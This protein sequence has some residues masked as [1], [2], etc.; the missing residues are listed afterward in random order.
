MD[1]TPCK[2]GFGGKPAYSELQKSKGRLRDSNSC[3]R[4]G[5][6]VHTCGGDQ[7]AT[8]RR[9]PQERLPEW[10][11]T[12]E[13]AHLSRLSRTHPNPHSPHP[14]TPSTQNTAHLQAPSLRHSLSTW[15]RCL[16]YGQGRPRCCGQF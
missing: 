11:R 5:S 6:G 16:R 13:R 10:T 9:G 3:P 2:G 12:S 15:W 1:W 4:G 8:T 7:L 14:C